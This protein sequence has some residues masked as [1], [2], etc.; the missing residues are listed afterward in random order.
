MNIRAG[1]ILV[2]Q[3]GKYYRVLEANEYSVSLKR[4][5]GHTIFACR[6]QYVASAFELASSRPP[7][8]R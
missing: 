2:S 5:D 3:D 6:P 1:E 8:A 4:V 7:V